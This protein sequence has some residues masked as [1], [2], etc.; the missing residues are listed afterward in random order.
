MESEESAVEN[1]PEATRA[2]VEEILERDG[3]DRAISVLNRFRAAEV[4][5]MIRDEYPDLD[6]DG[7]SPMDLTKKYLLGRLKDFYT[8]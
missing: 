4:R 1:K 3:I 6:L 2:S 8:K 5:E 7:E